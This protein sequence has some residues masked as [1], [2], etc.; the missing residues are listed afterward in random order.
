MCYF[1]YDGKCMANEKS[2]TF[3]DNMKLP[4]HRWF[5]YSAGF[6]SQWVADVIDKF[7]KNNETEAIVLDPFSGSGTT[8]ITCDS[9]NRESY[10]FDGHSF[11]SKIANAKKAWML[12]I[13]ELIVVMNEILHLSDSLKIDSRY[14]NGSL[15]DKC[16]EKNVL[17]ELDRIKEA[18]FLFEKDE[19]I[20]KKILDVIWLNITSI[21][22]VCS[23]VGTAQWQYILPNKRKAKTLTPKEAISMKMDIIISDI[24]YAVL[25]NWKDRSVIVNKDARHSFKTKNKCNLMVTSPPYPNN[26]DYA[27]ATRLEM[28]FWGEIDGWKDLKTVL[29]P[30]LMRSCSQHS[31]VEK[32]SLD[33]LLQSDELRPIY[34]D[35]YK[36]TKELD[37]VRHTKGG[38]KTYH[39][40][41]AAYFLD[42]QKILVNAKNNMSDNSLS[43]FVIGDSAPY[44]VYVPADK[45]IGDLA[46][47]AGFKSFSFE[48]IRDRNI[49]WKNRT[50]TVPL[51]EGFLWIKG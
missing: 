40:M 10:G 31:A 35:I 49:K 16:Y 32:L 24:E 5:R 38:K 25:N 42:I 50:H 23:F 48:K 30:H 20:D 14:G 51:H 29:R 12:N 11:V 18:Y 45:W 21:L 22:R 3:I 33:E 19:S 43:C 37:I 28:T 17:D 26:Y 7:E 39:T 1:R 46:L 47:D 2:G 27:D 44:G 8:N 4:V 34:D 6:S 13:N 9:L 41:I 15:L 36:V